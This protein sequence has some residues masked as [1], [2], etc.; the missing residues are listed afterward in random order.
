MIHSVL[1]QYPNLRVVA[2]TLRN[3]K[4]ATVNDWGAICY[5]AGSFFEARPFPNLEIFDRVLAEE[6]PLLPA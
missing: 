5:H 2:T 6:I 1:A 4:T 3:A